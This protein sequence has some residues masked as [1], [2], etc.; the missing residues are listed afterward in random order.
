MRNCLK[1]NIH[2]FKMCAPLHLPNYNLNLFLFFK[3]CHSS[4]EEK[5]PRHYAESSNARLHSVE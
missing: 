2:A 3:E 5:T 1:N 4:A